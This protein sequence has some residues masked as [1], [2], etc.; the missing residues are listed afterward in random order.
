MLYEQGDT[1]YQSCGDKRIHSLYTYRSYIEAGLHVGGSS[2]CPVVSPSP[3]LGMRDSILRKTEAGRILAP[4]QCLE[5]KIALQ[6]FTRE[7][8]Y[9]LFEENKRGTIETGKAADFVVLSANPFKT[10]VETWEDQIKVEMTIVGGEV[11][12]QA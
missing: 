9:T 10:L 7:A 8:A 3:L 1:F 5:P 2:D 12:Y 4:E 11:V 6:M